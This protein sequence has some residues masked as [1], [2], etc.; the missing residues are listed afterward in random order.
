MRASA[1]I[2]ACFA[3]ALGGCSGLD[4]F[5]ETIVDETIIPF[6]QMAGAPFQPTFSMGAFNDVDLSAAQEFQN[7]GVSPGD[8]DAIYIT[9][10]RLDLAT[11]ANNPAID[12]LDNFIEA[13][14]FFVEAPGL[15]RQVIAR[16]DT[17]P[18]TASVELD[19]VAEDM[20][21]GVNLKPYATAS[22]MRIGA[23]LQLRPNRAVNATLTTTIQM[24][25]DINLLGL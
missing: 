9:S 5:E 14:E 12:Q 11:G 10:I 23:D 7:N 15:P 2:P 19:I 4:E 13:V 17:M 6:T 25:I 8:V 24:L 16:R 18:D 21:P 1:A 20:L 3:V 22:S